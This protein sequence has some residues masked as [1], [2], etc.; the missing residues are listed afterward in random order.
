M[1]FGVPFI[2]YTPGGLK[3]D[4]KARVLD[5]NDNPIPRLY[6][7]G[8]VT[9]GIFGK[10]RLGTCAVPDALVFGRIAGGYEPE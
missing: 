2:H 1:L 6:A 10:D 5:E 9:G 3:I 4:K 7:A 8:E